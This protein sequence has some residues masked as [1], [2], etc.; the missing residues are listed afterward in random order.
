VGDPA[1][2]VFKFNEIY[3]VAEANSFF[4]FGQIIL[5]DPK[6]S[7]YPMAMADLAD[8]CNCKW[9]QAQLSAHEYL[10]DLSP[11]SAAVWLDT[12]ILLP[13]TRQDILI[14]LSNNPRRLQIAANTAVVT[15]GADVR[16][17]TPLEPHLVMNLTFEA[18]GSA[19]HLFGLEAIIINAI[20][21]DHQRR[22][23]SKRWEAFGFG[24]VGRK[25]ISDIS[26]KPAFH[27]F[28][29]ENGGG[30]FAHAVLHIGSNPGFTRGG[31]PQYNF[32]VHGSSR[33][34]ILDS[35][36]ITANLS[37]PRPL[38]VM[39]V[40]PL[41][42][43]A[44]PKRF[45]SPLEI[46][47]AYHATAFVWII[48]NHRLEISRAIVRGLSLSNKAARVIHAAIKGL[49]FLASQAEDRRYLS[50]LQHHPR[51]GLV[52]TAFLKAGMSPYQAIRR[53]IYSML[54]ELALLQ[55]ATTIVCLVPGVVIGDFTVQLG[56]GSFLVKAITMPPVKGRRR[57]V[58]AYAMGVELSEAGGAM[59]G[60]F[61]E[62]LLSR[63]DWKPIDSR[64][65]FDEYHS[66]AGTLLVAA[67]QRVGP[68]IQASFGVGSDDIP[69]L[70][71][72]GEIDRLVKRGKAAGLVEVVHHAE[73]ATWMARNFP[74]LPDGLADHPAS[75][76]D[77]LPK[78]I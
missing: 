37:E 45:L 47:S 61:V 31:D 4:D 52:G 13:A 26:V 20:G 1:I 2:A 30:V 44:E 74:H 65:E 19:M 35:L 46:Q 17:I 51:F 3:A 32:V 60:A 43:L 64:T 78:F 75:G 38:Q 22:S 50:A 70:I 36:S 12:A 67:V 55:T 54:T 69:R 68:A 66:I 9:D 14:S 10:K 63:W 62:L 23:S 33:Q 76:D 71:V 40:R 24:G 16:V 72:A 11:E 59:Y 53:A 56:R 77:F 58:I 39:N 27:A 8:L 34:D 49:A 7:N 48:A 25:V 29:T 18:L 5:S 21:Q 73:I 42:H 15:V 6:A 57:E 28:N 41:S